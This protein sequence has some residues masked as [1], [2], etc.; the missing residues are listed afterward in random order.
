[1]L[2]ALHHRVWAQL[3]FIMALLS[4]FPNQPPTPQIDIDYSN[5]S[6]YWIITIRCRDRAKLLFDTGCGC[7]QT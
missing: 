2:H 5:D 4:Q 6:D 7:S 1:M 3:L